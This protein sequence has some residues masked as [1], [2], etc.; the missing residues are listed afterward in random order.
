MIGLDT[1]VLLAWTVEGQ[2]RSLK[3]AETYRVSHVALMEYQW[4]LSNRFEY[5]K[6]AVI[7]ALR[8]LVEASNVVVDRPAVVRA[9]IDDYDSGGADFMDFLIMR[10]NE[11][12]GCTTTLTLD[13]RASRKP[14]FTYLRS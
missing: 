11:A 9:A 2:S 8:Q 10:D 5:P 13:Q 1:N 12:A 3:A 7:L 6:E 4:A 14:G